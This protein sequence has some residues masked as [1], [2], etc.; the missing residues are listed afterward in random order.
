VLGVWTT[1]FWKYDHQT[2]E[3][4][5]DTVVLTLDAMEEGRYPI[6][7][8]ETVDAGRETAVKMSYRLR[9]GEE[10][11]L[12]FLADRDPTTALRFRAHSGLIWVRPTP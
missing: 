1:D 4:L 9:T 2:L 8:V 5:P 10:R 3:L 6:T 7:K 11:E 12:D